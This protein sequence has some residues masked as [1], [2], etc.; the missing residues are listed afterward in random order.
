MAAEGALKF[1]VVAVNDAMIKTK[2][3]EMGFYSG[4]GEMDL[5]TKQA[6]S[7]GGMSQVQVQGVRDHYLTYAQWLGRQPQELMRSRRGGRER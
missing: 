6:Q 2:A 7:M 5:A 1:R 3:F 4:K